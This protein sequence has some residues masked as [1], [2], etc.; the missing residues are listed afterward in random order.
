MQYRLKDSYLIYQKRQINLTV[1]KSMRDL[2]YIFFS[3]ILALRQGFKS[4]YSSHF[5]ESGREIKVYCEAGSKKIYFDVP[6]LITPSITNTICIITV[7][8]MY[9]EILTLILQ[10]KIRLNAK[11][12]LNNSPHASPLSL[13]K[14]KT[15]CDKR[16]FESEINI[17]I[18]VVNF[19]KIIFRTV[20]RIEQN[21]VHK[22]AR[23]FRY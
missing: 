8:H 6:A 3:T 14:K 7:L 22:V 4:R 18:K 17:P 1:Q 15:M 12:V 16:W 5:I 13:N 10:L 19:L 9:Y 11:R 23:R 2:Q 21:L 20:V